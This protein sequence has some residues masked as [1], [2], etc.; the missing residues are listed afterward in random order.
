M[1]TPISLLHLICIQNNTKADYTLL[2]REG[3]VHLPTFTFRVQVNQHIEEASG[4]SKKKAKHLAAKKM[5]LR[6]FD[7]ESIKIKEDRNVIIESLKDVDES[8]D[9]I[10]NKR[11][12]ELNERQQQQFGQSPKET[13]KQMQPLNQSSLICAELDNPIGKLQ[14]I[15]MKKHWHPPI[16]MEAES[17]GLPHERLFT[18]KCFIENMNMIVLGQGKSKKSAK[19]DAAEK[20]LEV[21]RDE[22][23]D[24]VDEILDRI[25]SKHQ[26]NQDNNTSNNNPNAFNLRQEIIAYQSS[27]NKNRLM[28][29][30]LEKFFQ[31]ISDDKS[32]IDE[33]HKLIP[34]EINEFIQNYSSNNK[35]ISDI[36]IILDKLINIIKC[37]LNCV[38]H[39][40]KSQLDQY[41]YWAELIGCESPYENIAILSAWGVDDDLH[42][43]RQKAMTRLLITFIWYCYFDE[44]SV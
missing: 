31:K 10:E 2:S 29:I 16:Y 25:P 27:G 43:A 22:H 14:E 44:P 19:R 17:T 18:F 4:Q 37:K 21:L 5:I 13:S 26:A 34:V 6:L 20:M 39:P 36:D 24:K 40:E 9:I 12:Q 7:D 42:Q 35:I 33:I 28:E 11:N 1:D 30:N 38:L 23:L 41:Q 8:I 3:Q 15:C 32:V